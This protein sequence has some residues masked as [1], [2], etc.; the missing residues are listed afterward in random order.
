MCRRTKPTIAGSTFGH[1]G[2]I[3]KQAKHFIE[4]K[5]IISNTAQFLPSCS[6][7]EFLSDVL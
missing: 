1:P 3:S 5:P 6:Y 2:Q 4:S 7:L